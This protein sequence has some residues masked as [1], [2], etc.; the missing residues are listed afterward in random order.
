M[1]VAARQKSCGAGID[2]NLVTD[3]TDHRAFVPVGSISKR[4]PDDSIGAALTVD[5]YHEFSIPSGTSWSSGHPMI[6]CDRPEARGSDGPI[7]EEAGDC[8]GRF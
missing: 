3:A 8:V 2:S 7:G 5:A 6:Q 1:F 4:T